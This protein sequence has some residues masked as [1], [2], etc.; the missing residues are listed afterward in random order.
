[1][2]ISQ[3]VLDKAAVYSLAFVWVF[4]G[5]TSLFFAPDIGLDI[6]RNVSIVGRLADACVYAGSIIDIGIGCWLLTGLKAKCCCIVQVTVIVTY[7]MLLS[8]IDIAYWLHPFGPITK[9]LPIIVLI[10]F[11]Y[12][13]N[14]MAEK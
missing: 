8:I 4:T 14:I 3:Y 11:V 12:K 1:M 6:L 10:F 5:L 2:Q 9:N 13:A 7:T